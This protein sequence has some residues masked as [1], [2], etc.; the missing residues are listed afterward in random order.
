MARADG[1]IIIDTRIDN[2]EVDGDLGKLQSKLQKTAANSVSLGSKMSQ[3]LAKGI[4]VAAQIGAEA[5]KVSVEAI[6]AITKQAVNSFAEY[7][8]LAGGVNK[9][10]D[11]MDTS[12]IFE[13][14]ANAYRDLGMSANEY[15]A[16]I[17]NVGA[18]F[19]AT[20]GDKKGYDTAKKGLQAI[21]DYATGTGGNIEE[22]T[23][24]YKLITKSTSSYQGV[25][26]QFSALLPQ[27]SADFL[28]QAQAAGLLSKKYEK[29]TDVPV[30]EYQQAVTA[31]LERGV[32]ALGLTGNTAE[33]A[34]KTLS[35]S[36][37]M[38]S[39]AWKN[40]I[41]GL[42]DGSADITAL[43]QNMVDSILAVSR[44]IVP[45]IQT[46]LTGAGSLL[47]NIAPIIAAELPGLV[48]TLLPPLLSAAM[49][50]INGLLVALPSL[51]S[52]LVQQLIPMLISFISESL[53]LLINS[54]ISIIVTLLNGVTQALPIL[55]AEIPKIVTTVVSTLMAPGNFD[56]ILA[57]GI[58]LLLALID[59]IPVIIVELVNALPF[60]IETI[61]N[62]LSNAAPLILEAALQALKSIIT[63]I[64]EIR[65]SVKENM[66]SVGENIVKGIWSGISN[67]F[68]WLKDKLT[69][70][71]GDVM[72]WLKGV[73]GIASPSKLMRDE[74][75]KFM[76][77]GVGVGFTLQMPEEMKHMSNALDIVGNL[78]PR[79]PQ[80]ATGVIIP[81]MARL[82]DA[83]RT[84]TIE[85][86]ESSN[87][88][89]DSFAALINEVK[90]LGD[91]IEEMQV[92]L[93]S[94]KTVGGILTEADRQL[95]KR[96]VLTKRGA[97]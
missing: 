36:L 31:M 30:A 24:K 63:A 23:E 82:S 21:S 28:K 8:Q 76:A 66:L 44:N 47:Q 93:D 39:A 74:I 46:V 62:A 97:Y 16:A 71:V 6:V 41:T 88:T 84:V 55:A 18:T 51:I 35:G 25:V 32:D 1:T 67:S 56:A 38:M 64:L 52:T 9:I 96:Q 29:L 19:A 45:V 5:L 60:I 43:T 70:W 49:T 40:L 78:K 17:N 90:A 2:S 86:D 12:A 59:A 80:V 15:L 65:E 20:M 81:P 57:A 50:L 61:Y 68:Q 58:A 87:Y 75:G 42:G 95:G 22:L 69:G 77:E 26:D 85:R 91:R 7:E 14:A 53:P 34:E 48:S 11:Q 54:G 27:T 83:K 3:A 89:A 73:L 13:D 79:I 94:R 33:E 4:S 37:G 72:S 92:V 10:F